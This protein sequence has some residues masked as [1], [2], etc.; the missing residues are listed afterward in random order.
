MVG[1]KASK[2][3][4]ADVYRFGQNYRLSK[5]GEPIYDEAI[6]PMGVFVM[7]EEPQPGAAYTIGVDPSW[8]L[9]RG[10][11]RSA[12]HVLRNGTLQRPDEQVGEFVS[13]DLNVHELIPIC[14]LLGNLYS[15]DGAEALMTVE[16]NMGEE[17]VYDLQMKYN[18]GNIFVRKSYDHAQRVITPRKGWLTTPRTRP[19]LISKA[20][21]YVKQDWWG[22][23][24]PW[25]VNELQTIEKND[26][27][28]KI[29]A[30][31]G[32]HD[33]LFMAG[34]IALWSAHD[35]EFND[36][37]ESGALELAAKRQRRKDQMVD[38]MYHALAPMDK[39]IDYANTECSAEEAENDV[40]NLIGRNH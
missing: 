23:N 26:E 38:G 27:N 34:A 22:I 6:P 21:Q 1:K 13:E 15:N 7:W 32:C 9:G 10:G 29:M 14:Y 5:I 2:N 4:K 37:F 31:R 3:G 24:S 39:R 12:I 33:D 40:Y 16:V 20:M 25:L 18:Y 36:D 28:Q 30:A 19:R 35:L 17:I 8:G 11:D